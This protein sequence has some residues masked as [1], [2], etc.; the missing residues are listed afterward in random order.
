M[1]ATTVGYRFGNRAAE[2]RRKPDNRARLIMMYNRSLSLLSNS[3]FLKSRLVTKYAVMTEHA[4]GDSPGGR[5]LFEG[6]GRVSLSR[7][8]VT[9]L[10]YSCWLDQLIIEHRR[11]VINRRRWKVRRRR[12]GVSGGRLLAISIVDE[13][14]DPSS[15]HVLRPTP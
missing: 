7:R 8:V 13:K 2:E 1:R 15:F 9:I 6:R 12:K 4:G 10:R 14:T 11:Y 3:K 5:L